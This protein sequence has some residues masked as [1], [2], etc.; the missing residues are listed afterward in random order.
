MLVGVEHINERTRTAFE[1]LA[2]RIRQL[3]CGARSLFERANAHAAFGDVAEFGVDAQLQIAATGFQQFVGL[4]LLCEGCSHGCIHIAARIQGHAQLHADVA[5]GVARTGRSDVFAGAAA[6]LRHGVQRGQVARA[7]LFDFQL[8]GIAPGTQLSQFGAAIFGLREPALQTARIGLPTVEAGGVQLVQA[9][10]FDR[11]VDQHAKPPRCVVALLQGFEFIGQRHVQACL[12]FVDIG[13]RS[14]ACCQQLA[15]GVQLRGRGTLLR[16]DER[17]LI[18]GQQGLHVGLGHARTQ[19]LRF[20][21]EHGVG[22]VALAARLLQSHSQRLAVQRL[23]HHDG[24][25]VAGVFFIDRV[26]IARDGGLR[27][28]QIVAHIPGVQRDVGIELG[29]GLLDAFVAHVGIGARGPRGGV[30]LERGFV[31]FEQIHRACGCALQPACCG[32]EREPR[33]L[34]WLTTH[35]YC[36]LSAPDMRLSSGPSR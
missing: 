13:A 19:V 36:S 6:P 30:L 25:V 31:G 26:G 7:G 8:G 35:A 20:L 21:V 33:K 5:V 29:L 24:G 3:A 12:R 34:V 4:L 9:A 22:L 1:R 10:R 14:A 11:R 16:G 15:R 32:N 2:A 18:V 28:V 17:E 23:A 27:Q